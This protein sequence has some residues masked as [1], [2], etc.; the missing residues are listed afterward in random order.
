MTAIN[1][2]SSLLKKLSVTTAGTALT[3]IGLIGLWCK[4]AQAVVITSGCVSPD[5]CNL[6]EL[7]N[8]GTIT[9]EDKIFND[10]S[11]FGGFTNKPVSPDLSLIDVIPLDDDP[12][13]PGLKFNAN[14]QL[15]TV[16]QEFISIEFGFRLATLDGSARIKDKSLELTGLEFGADSG[17]I[18]IDESV[19]DGNGN[20]LGQNFVVFD[21]LSGNFALFDS[22]D[23]APQPSIAVRKIIG[24]QGDK[25][26]DTISLNMFEQRFSQTTV[27]EP[28]FTLGLLALGTVAAGSAWKHN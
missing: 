1:Y 12:L 8:G 19:V 15:S 26:G 5:Q 14:D 24:I 21:P 3:L 6:E 28:N 10:W 4:E 17:L 7:F 16:D 11:F 18:L 23:F 9:I 22:V 13:N 20:S 27:P 2:S 25:I